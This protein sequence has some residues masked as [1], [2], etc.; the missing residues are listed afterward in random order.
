M[1]VLKV[2]LWAYLSGCCAFTHVAGSILIAKRLKA[3]R[4][5]YEASRFMGAEINILSDDD[6]DAIYRGIR[7]TPLP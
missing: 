1:R 5:R 4:E 2:A 6:V 7:K 3:N